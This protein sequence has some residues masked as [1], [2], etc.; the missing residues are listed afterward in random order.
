[1][2]KIVP[3]AVC[4][5]LMLVFYLMYEGDKFSKR[6]S[7]PFA[8][9]CK[10]A[11]TLCACLLAAVG[12]ARTGLGSDWALAAGLLLCTVAD[13]V[14]DLRFVAGMGVFSLGHAAYCA[15]YI[16]KNPP[17]TLNFLLM[18]A[19]MVSVVLGA[20]KFSRRLGH[21]AAPFTLYALVLCVM[22]SLA[23]TQKPVLAFGA[24]FFVISDA[25]LARNL[26][27]GAT[28]RQ[29][30]ASLGCYYLGQFLIAASVWAF[31]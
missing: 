9:A 6:Y 22:L 16:L 3:V 31:A 13:V 14:L 23:A 20:L 7:R 5:G 4:F 24:L 8:I 30:Y 12:A 15:A 21:R 18:V 25:T 29:D 11:A 17:G 27:L 28:R 1:M 2:G 19:L 26:L 10:G